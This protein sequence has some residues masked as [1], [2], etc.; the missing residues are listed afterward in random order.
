VVV[1]PFCWVIGYPGACSLG[2][3]RRML[4]GEDARNDEEIRLF[5]LG[6]CILHL[7]FER[8]PFLVRLFEALRF[9]AGTRTL[10]D[11]GELPVPILRSV[12]PSMRPD[13]G[14]MLDAA[15][16]AGQSTF[17]EVIDVERALA[18]EDPLRARLASALR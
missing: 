8:S 18:L 17:S 10:P 12:V 5:V 14:L 4:A 2:A 9:E 16:L 6:S 11:T 7:L 15:D 1:S 13:P 3:L